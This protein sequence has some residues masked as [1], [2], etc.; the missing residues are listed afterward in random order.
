MGILDDELQARRAA[1][2]APLHGYLD[3]GG[4]DPA[5][6]ARLARGIGPLLTLPEQHALGELLR[7]APGSETGTARLKAWLCRL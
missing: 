1:V 3:G 5:E 2:A 6:I 4:R 7:E